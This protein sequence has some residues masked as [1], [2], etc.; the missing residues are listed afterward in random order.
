LVFF[1]LWIQF[2]Q[3]K[4]VDDYLPKKYRK[5]VIFLALLI[6]TFSIIN[7]K[8]R[9]IRVR[10]GKCYDYTLD[11]SITSERLKVLGKLGEYMILTTLNNDTRY[12]VPLGSKDDFK[13]QTFDSKKK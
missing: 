6:L 11:P 3:S 1:V 9:G 10:D 7:S 8:S 5:T 4:I 2:S 12:I 13:I